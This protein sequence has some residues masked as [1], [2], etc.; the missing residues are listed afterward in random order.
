MMR[1]LMI[2]TVIFFWK[3][4]EGQSI[5]ESHFVKKNHD[6]ISLSIN[7]LIQNNTDSNLYYINA[8]Y[9]K[10]HDDTI[11]YYCFVHGNIPEFKMIYYAP[12]GNSVSIDSVNT[13]L[14]GEQLAISYRYQFIHRKK[15]I[16]EQLRVLDFVFSKRSLFNSFNQYEKT[17]NIYDTSAKEISCK[18]YLKT[19]R[20]Y[21]VTT[22]LTGY[23]LEHHYPE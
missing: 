17:F 22:K 7:L 5:K 8:T 20:K 2:L 1:S 6:T 16:K 21:S 3:Y 18:I 23:T 11:V 14:P 19:A 13:V 12:L 15:K 4:S 9:G 10:R